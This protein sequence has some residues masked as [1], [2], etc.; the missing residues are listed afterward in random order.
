MDSCFVK[1]GMKIFYK[2]SKVYKNTKYPGCLS[3]LDMETK[4]LD[5]KN[6]YVEKIVFLINCF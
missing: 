5:Y 2:N 1:C 3:L 4:K 6:S